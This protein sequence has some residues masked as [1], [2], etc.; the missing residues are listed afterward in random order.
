[1]I[2]EGANY[3]SG[4]FAV[5]GTYLDDDTASEF[6]SKNYPGIASNAIIGYQEHYHD[7]TTAPGFT[8]AQ[9]QAE[10]DNAI[11]GAAYFVELHPNTFWWFKQPI[12]GT[13]WI[14]YMYDY[15]HLYG[16]CF[17]PH[18]VTYEH[19]LLV[20]VKDDAIHMVNSSGAGACHYAIYDAAGRSV[21]E[22]NFTTVAGDNVIEIKSLGLQ[23]S[24]YIVRIDCGK[25]NTVTQKLFIK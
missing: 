17:Q 18:R 14:S 10:F 7:F 9:F 1:M 8:P 15:F 6:L 19:T 3:F 12:W 2:H 11:T 21:Y 22:Q 23:P 16:A 4:C 24:I 25:N 20:S 13:Q 5:N